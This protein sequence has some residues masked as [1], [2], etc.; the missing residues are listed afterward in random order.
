MWRVGQNIDKRNIAHFSGHKFQIALIVERSVMGFQQ[1]RIRITS[2]SS[3]SPVISFQSYRQKCLLTDLHVLTSCRDWVV[4]SSAFTGGPYLHSMMYVCT[5]PVKTSFEPIH[6]RC[7]HHFLRQIVPHVDYSVDEEILTWLS[8]TTSLCQFQTM[9]PT[10]CVCS[11][12][13]EDKGRESLLTKQIQFISNRLRNNCCN[14]GLP[15]RAIAHQ[16]WAPVTVNL[17]YLK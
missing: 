11:V 4:V 7:H 15:V 9:T 1:G 10:I 12:L 6:C 14:G 17:I 3:S 5:V 13:V 8:S 16:Y 2:S